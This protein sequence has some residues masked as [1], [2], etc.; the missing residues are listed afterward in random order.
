[1]IVVVNHTT[2]E[3]FIATEDTYRRLLNS[4]CF[5]LDPTKVMR[6]SKRKDNIVAKEIPTE[7][8]ANRIA[9]M[10]REE[11]AYNQVYF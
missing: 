2:R 1:M 9:H 6:W 7:S 5:T 8:L 4:L 3:F 11:R 10:F